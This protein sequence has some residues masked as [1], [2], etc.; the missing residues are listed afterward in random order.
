MVNA[1]AAKDGGKDP[2]KTAVPT[3]LVKKGKTGGD[4]DEGTEGKAVD[5]AA[6]QKFLP[7]GLSRSIVIAAVIG[8]LAV[9]AGN[10]FGNRFNLVP[11][12]NSTNG[13]MYRIDHLTGAVQFCG[14]QGCGDIPN[15]GSEK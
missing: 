6:K 8:S 14:P 13:F 2:S 9:I 10:L 1:D 3:V 5:G 4:D 11:A 15:R 7:T 12:P